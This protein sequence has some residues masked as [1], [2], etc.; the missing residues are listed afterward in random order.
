[1][2]FQV[3]GTAPAPAARL[4]LFY[5]GRKLL[6]FHLQFVDATVDLLP[7]QVASAAVLANEI[8][9]QFDVP[10][11]LFKVGLSFVLAPGPAPV[12]PHLEQAFLHIDVQLGFLGLGGDVRLAVG[13]AVL[14]GRGHQA[15]PLHACYEH[16]VVKLRVRELVVL[17]QERVE[18]FLDAG[19]EQGAHQVVGVRND[20]VV[21]AHGAGTGQ[22][23]EQDRWPDDLG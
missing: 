6:L 16:G 20:A 12:H 8:V 21:Q 18:Q 23:A 2:F 7:G 4:A 15:P 9:G 14:E 1:M 22:E 13:V 10:V 5:P 11:A 19:E 17:V 3:G